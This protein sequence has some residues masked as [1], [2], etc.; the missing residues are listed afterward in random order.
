MGSWRLRSAIVAAGLGLAALAPA[1]AVA[2]V[3]APVNLGAGE[4]PNLT[5]A[6]DGTAHIAWTGAGANSKELDYC[7]LPRGAT[8]CSPKTIIN[9]PGDSLSKPLPFA[10]GTTISV[11]SYR[12][13]LTSGPF[14]AVMLFT[15]TDGG[16]TFDTGTTIGSIAPFDFT[17][18]PGDNVSGVTAADSCGLCF[19]AWPLAGGPASGPAV[20]S[21]DHLYQSSIAMI[22]P[23]TPIAVFA[24]AGGDAQFRRYSGNGDVN[25]AANWTPAVDIGS[26]DFTHLVSGSGGVFLVGQDQLSGTIM[27]ARKFDGTTFGSRV[28]ITT[29][30]RPDHAAEDALGRVHVVGGSFDGGPTGASLFYATSDSGTAWE[31]QRVVFPGVPS[32]MRLAIASDHFGTVVGGYATGPTG[33]LF[34]SSIGPSAAVPATTKF[35]DA[36]VVSGTVLIQVPPSQKFVRLQTGD[37]IPVGSTVDTTNGRVRITIALPSG[38]LQATDFF[39]GIF[40]VT[41]AKAGLATMVLG[42]GSF[43]SCGARAGAIAAKAKVIRQLWGNGAGQFRTKGRY[44]TAAIRGTTWDTVDRCDGTLIK[45][46]KG[47]IL[48]TDLKTKKKIT[49]AAGQSYLAKA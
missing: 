14:S 25:D 23:T 7:R 41:Q 28:T 27:Q 3:G 13:G 45:V 6:D 10:V 24:T 5:V 21:T 35:V 18:G 44:A 31:T 19:Q 39:Q 2:A 36:T 46:T 17:F 12:Y 16:A 48:V 29:G 32:D 15:S 42:G 1:Q 11:I 8:A 47:R 30:V 40:K 33:T 22:D 38:K 9:A 49:L 37:V 26:L 4:R 43:K 34:A 20:L